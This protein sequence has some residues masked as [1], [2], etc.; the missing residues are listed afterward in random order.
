MVGV[1]VSEYRTQKRDPRIPG[2]VTELELYHAWLYSEQALKHRDAQRSLSRFTQDLRVS[3]NDP[4]IE[5]MK[6][7]IQNYVTDTAR[8]A[9]A[10]LD[11]YAR[12]KGQ[13][14][15]AER[16]NRPPPAGL[17]QQRFKRDL[18]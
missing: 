3:A 18:M 9:R 1:A 5:P 10:G 17:R 6:E 12:A 4:D 15:D 8:I 14:E 7:K 16:E 2:S 11:A 13:S